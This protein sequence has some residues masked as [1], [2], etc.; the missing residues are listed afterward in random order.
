M[1]DTTSTALSLGLELGFLIYL[2]CNVCFFEMGS[3]LSHC[4]MFVMYLCIAKDG[5]QNSFVTDYREL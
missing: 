5:K 4:V 3:S 2:P 1:N